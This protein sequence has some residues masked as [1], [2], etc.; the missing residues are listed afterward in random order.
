MDEKVYTQEVIE[1]TAFPNQAGAITYVESDSS[2]NAEISTQTTIKEQA[3]PTKKLATELISSVLNTKSRKIVGEIQFTP[4]GAL[5]IGNYQE[6]I[7]GDLRLAPSG[8][9]MRNKQGVETI[10]QDGETG[11][12]VFAGRIQSGTLVTGVILVGDGNIQIDG[13]SRKMLWY[14]ADGLPSIVIGLV[15]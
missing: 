4:S 10:A 3:I 7:S 5:Q 13:P 6:G 1:D 9:V 15:S 12:A 2:A 11:D 8:L 14:A